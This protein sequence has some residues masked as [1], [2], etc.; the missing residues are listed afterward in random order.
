MP[1]LDVRG[2]RLGA[3]AGM[4]HGQWHVWPN[5]TARPSQ[6]GDSGSILWSE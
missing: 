1:G 2:L 3:L 4:E 6:M 5:T